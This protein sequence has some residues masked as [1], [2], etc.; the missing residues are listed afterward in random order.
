MQGI[1]FDWQEKPVSYRGHKSATVM[2][3]ALMRSWGLEHLVDIL[4]QLVGDVLRPE[5]AFIHLIGNQLILDFLLLNFIFRK[6][7]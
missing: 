4:A 2:A 5:V 3:A 7:K 1:A 6:Q